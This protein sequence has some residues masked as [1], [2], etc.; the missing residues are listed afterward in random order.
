[1]LFDFAKMQELTGWIESSDTVRSQGMS[2]ANLVLQKSPTFQ[3]AIFFTLLN[4]QPN[5]AGFAG[6]K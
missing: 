4:P 5:G 6:M 1:M 2:K 3:R